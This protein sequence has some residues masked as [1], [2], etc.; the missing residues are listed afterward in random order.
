MWV[1]VSGP[2][3]K[4]KMQVTPKWTIDK[5]CGKTI[6]AEILSPPPDWVEFVIG[7]ELKNDPKARSFIHI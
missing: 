1:I 5:G 4:F 6:G 7:F 3:H 2:K